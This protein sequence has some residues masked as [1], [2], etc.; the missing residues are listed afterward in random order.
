VQRG[1]EF[2]PGG[3]VLDGGF[4]HVWNVISHNWQPV[5]GEFDLFVGSSSRDIRLT[6][7]L[8]ASSHV[9]EVV[10]STLAP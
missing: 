3:Q 2:L 6:G 7:K 10:E 8:T 4:G 5:P 1:I 9:L